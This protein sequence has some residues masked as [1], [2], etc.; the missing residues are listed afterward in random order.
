MYVQCSCVELLEVQLSGVTTDVTIACF[1]LLLL[2]LLLPPPH[3]AGNK[4]IDGILHLH[5]IA[6]R[7][8]T[9]YVTLDVAPHAHMLVIRHVLC[10]LHHPVGKTEELVHVALHRSQDPVDLGAGCSRLDGLHVLQ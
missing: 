1:L 6:W 10:P 4:A 9:C 5:C 7:M 2:L 3:R 8:R